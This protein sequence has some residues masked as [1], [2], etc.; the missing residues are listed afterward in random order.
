MSESYIIADDKVKEFSG[1]NIAGLTDVYENQ[2]YFKFSD[3]CATSTGLA[4]SSP[5]KNIDFVKSKIT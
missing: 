5:V 1:D 2:A 3:V 4:Q